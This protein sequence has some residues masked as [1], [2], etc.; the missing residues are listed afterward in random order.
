MNPFPR[1]RSVLVLD[2]VNS[3]ISKNLAIIC[4]KAGVYLEYLPLYSPNYNPIEEFFFTL[5]A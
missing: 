3:Y 5:K 1:L 4:E 2:N